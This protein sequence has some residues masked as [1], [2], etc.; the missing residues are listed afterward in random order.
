MFAIISHFYPSLVFVG[1]TRS[2]PLEWNLASDSTQVGSGLAN[3]LLARAAVSVT[4]SHFC[5][6][7]VFAG[8]TRS[9]PLE[10]NLLWGFTQV[11]SG[12]ASLLH[13]RA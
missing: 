5:T 11:G 10:C 1:K 9:L 13:A 6:S 2:P 3:V 7:L 12:L 8:R 4:I